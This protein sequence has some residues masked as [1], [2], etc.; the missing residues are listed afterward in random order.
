MSELT[1][2]GRRLRAGRKAR[3]TGQRV[4]FRI[5]AL[6]AGVLSG[7]DF[8]KSPTEAIRL[9]A[10]AYAAFEKTQEELAQGVWVRFQGAPGETF[11]D[12]IESVYGSRPVDIYPSGAPGL[13]TKARIPLRDGM[14]AWLVVSRA[15]RQGPIT[16]G[17]RTADESRIADALLNALGRAPIWVDR[18]SPAYTL[19]QLLAASDYSQPQSAADREWVDAPAIGEEL[20]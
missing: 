19:D 18:A 11:K 7:F 12:R 14:S 20:I 17:E 1:H 9:L 3:T 5:D 16:D 13:T 2:G 4:T 10:D 6:T 15:G 8:D